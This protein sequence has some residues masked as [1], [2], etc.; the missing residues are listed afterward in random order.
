MSEI[1]KLPTIA[2]M[3]KAELRAYYLWLL[4]YRTRICSQMVAIGV[5]RA[6]AFGWGED[7]GPPSK[8]GP[9]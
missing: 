2:N 5:P 1:L 3:S 6:E 8:I 4:A 7:G 9:K